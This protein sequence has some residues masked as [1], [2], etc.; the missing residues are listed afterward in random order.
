MRQKVKKKKDIDLHKI[1]RSQTEL[2]NRW[3][4]LELNNVTN[5]LNMFIQ[6]PYPTFKI[7]KTLNQGKAINHKDYLRKK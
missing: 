2:M 7:N 4:Q 1:I 3:F 5:S 6:L